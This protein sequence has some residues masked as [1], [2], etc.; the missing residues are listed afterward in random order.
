M[1][2]LQYYEECWSNE[3]NIEYMPVNKTSL[4][5]PQHIIVSAHTGSTYSEPVSSSRSL[6]C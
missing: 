6:H 4:V 1:G 5:N 3:V 2:T